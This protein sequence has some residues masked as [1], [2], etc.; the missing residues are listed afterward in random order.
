MLTRSSI[1][2]LFI[3]LICILVFNLNM[4]AQITRSPDE[5]YKLF[6]GGCHGMKVEVMADRQFKNGQSIEEISASIVAGNIDEG[7]PAFTQVFT[8][9]ELKGLAQYIKDGISRVGEFEFE[10]IPKDDE[11]TQSAE[12]PFTLEKVVEGLQIPWGIEF[13]P[14]GS[15]LIAE[16]SGQLIRFKEGAKT[17]IQGLPS[18]R[19]RGQ[20][21][22]L[23]IELHPDYE[24]NGWIYYSFSKFNPVNDNES[25]TAIHRAKLTGNQFTDIEELFVALPY[26]RRAHHYGSRI[27]FDQDGY[28]F[29]SVGDRGNRDENP[30]NLDNHCGKI[31]RLHA[32]GSVPDDNPF[33]AQAP[34]FASIYSYGHRNPQGLSLNPETGEIWDNEHGPRGGDEINRII[35]GKN[36]GWPVISYGI[37]YDG[38]VFTAETHRPGMLQPDYYWV[39]SIGVCGMAFVTGDKY[40]GWRGDILSGS[41]KYQY[42]HRTDMNGNQV[43]G[44]ELLLK[45]IGRLRTVE[46]SPDGYIYV[47]VEAPTGAIYKLVPN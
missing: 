38:S 36:Y 27:E 7:M 3:C 32:D 16:K 2:S 25:T 12:Q 14:D 28:M 29:F 5:L 30:Q 1:P 33:V 18:V 13:L 34:N 41:L 24:S 10:G 15:L 21:G 23:D 11:L 43:V 6:C 26:S 44:Q 8:D 20:G 37:N 46:M 39:P 35:K 19:D 22:L 4:T 42:L 31:H 45:N 47:G 40:P 9:E 17:E